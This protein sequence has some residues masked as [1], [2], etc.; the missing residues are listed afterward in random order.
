MVTRLRILSAALSLVLGTAGGLA[1]AQ[2]QPP[3]PPPSTSPNDPNVSFTAQLLNLFSAE[4][5]GRFGGVE[6]FADSS[7]GYGV[8][9]FPLPFKADTR[10][11]YVSHPKYQEYALSVRYDDTTFAAG[12][13]YND[14]AGATEGVGHLEINHN[15]YT[16]LQYQALLQDHNRVS[17]LSAGWAAAQGPFRVYAEAG[18]A[19]QGT[20]NYDNV[21]GPD[22]YQES[23]FVHTE[24]SGGKSVTDGPATYGVY[25]TARGYF[26]PKSVQL[27][28]DLSASVTVRPTDYSSVT[29]SE[30]ERFAVGESQI[31]AYNF[32]RYSRSNVD[33]V[34]TPKLS[35]GALSL[36]S[37]EYH[38]RYSF[39]GNETTL[40]NVAFTARADV[41]PAFVLDLTP[42]YDNERSVN[43]LT[44]TSEGGVRADLF[45]RNDA[46]PVLIGPRIDYVFGNTTTASTAADGTTA[47]TVTPTNRWIISVKIGAK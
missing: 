3:Q 6:G 10:L 37:A 22:G 2:T 23:P 1:S 9:Y 40:N 18:Y 19:W 14:T 41:A 21:K 11:T 25:G 16:G 5:L 47:Y 43:G 44:V 33:V 35:A 26:F 36:R 28:T 13:Y 29:V 31:G 17:Q 32:G 7:N 24:V 15:P 27:S 38:F 45:Y 4:Y 39:L 8:R 12:R 20:G 46:L 34:A 42:H 30:F